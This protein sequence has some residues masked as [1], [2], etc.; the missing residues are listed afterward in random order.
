MAIVVGLSKP[1]ASGFGFAT[2]SLMLGDESTDVK[3]L[4][5]LGSGAS[6]AFAS[7]STQSLSL[8]FVRE[9]LHEFVATVCVTVM[10]LIFSTLMKSLFNHSLGLGLR[11]DSGSDTNETVS[12]VSPTIIQRPLGNPPISPPPNCAACLSSPICV[13]PSIK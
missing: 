11:F 2:T 9:T 6:P 10:D 1:N 13:L 4:V 12:F 3:P 7:A 8:S 5:L